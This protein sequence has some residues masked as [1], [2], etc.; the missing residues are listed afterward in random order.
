[1]GG[2]AQ[3]F[4]SMTKEEIEQNKA[5]L[6][7]GLHADLMRAGV[8]ADKADHMSHEMI[9]YFSK[10][11]KRDV[12]SSAKYSGRNFHSGHIK[13]LSK[14][15]FHGKKNIRITGF[16]CENGYGNEVNQE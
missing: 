7:I 12:Q 4:H 5:A 1:M 9:G 6:R 11:G 2:V 10:R 14:D 16:M 15:A 13:A 8:P 3:R